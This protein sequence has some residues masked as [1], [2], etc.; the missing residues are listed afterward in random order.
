VREV[1]FEG[2]ITLRG[3]GPS[4][5]AA[6][7]AVIGFA[8]PTTASTVTTGQ[9]RRALW[10]GPD[11][12]LLVVPDGEEQA[13]LDRLAGQLS[14]L[15]AAVVDVSAARTVIEIEGEKARALLERGCYLDLDPGTFKPGQCLSTTIAKV[16][17]AIELTREG[18]PCYRLYLRP[19]F[20]RHFAAW[21]SE[22]GRDLSD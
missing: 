11:E 5:H 4:F 2:K 15:N 22:A 12:W 17:I 7:Q 6:V 20:A 16:G 9:S 8:L 3:E 18:P 21:I 14:G 19:S 1:A 13:L 10:L